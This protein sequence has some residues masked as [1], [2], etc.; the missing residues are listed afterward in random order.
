MCLKKI[1]VL[2]SLVKIG[3]S[4]FRWVSIN[5]ACFFPV[6]IEEMEEERKSKEEDKDSEDAHKD[7]DK[8]TERSM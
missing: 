7:D 4:N 5:N 3:L 6:F 2:S 1:N 8:H